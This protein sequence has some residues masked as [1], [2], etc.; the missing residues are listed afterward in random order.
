MRELW[1]AGR[2]TDVPGV[3]ATIAGHLDEWFRTGRAQ[4]FDEAMA[5]IPEVVLELVRVPGVGPATAQKL[6]AAGVEDLEDLE[7]R[8]WPK[9]T[10]ARPSSPRRW[11]R[12]PKA[13]PSCCGGRTDAAAGGARRRGAPSSRSPR[14]AVGPPGRGGGQHTPRAATTVTSTSSWPPPTRPPPLPTCA[15]SPAWT[16]RRTNR[17]ATRRRSLA[18]RCTPAARASRS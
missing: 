7:R 2:L 13:W 4:R 12:S 6:A 8:R 1:Q 18:R 14:R 11:R 15:G 17:W 3:G 16:K 9:V 5:G 10:S